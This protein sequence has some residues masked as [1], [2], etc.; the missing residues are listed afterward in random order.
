MIVIIQD[1]QEAT[2]SLNREIVNSGEAYT[3]FS[4]TD[5]LEALEVGTILD[6]LTIQAI[7]VDIE[8]LAENT[9]QKIS[10]AI[11]VPII[12][13]AANRNLERMRALFS[14]GADDVV[15]KPVHIEEVFL[16]IAA[17]KRR[18]YKS[19]TP[20]QNGK[21]TLYFDGR[22]PEFDGQAIV[23]RRKERK[24][25][26]YLALINGRRATKSQ[27]FDSVYGL[28]QESYNEVLVE[29][30]MCRLRKNLKTI[31]GNDPINCTRHYGYQL[32]ATSIAIE[33]HNDIV[34]AA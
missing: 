28:D 34:L 7:I 19:L 1:P 10:K 14:N 13:L 15:T 22:D 23:L 31:I 27:I 12:F 4:R 25:L 17:I 2:C 24:I 20:Q 26:E 3:F 32:D 33:K 21:L 16:R 29:S 30:H 5:F 6:Q 8:T 9:L 18:T 11:R